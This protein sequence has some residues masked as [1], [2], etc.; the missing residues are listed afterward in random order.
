M[1]S[2]M[3]GLAVSTAI[4]IIYLNYVYMLGFPDGHVTEIE[5]AE[6]TIAYLFIAISVP[7]GLFCFASAILSSIATRR[8]I[9]IVVRSC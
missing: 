1:V 9:A 4:A 6:R 8:R 2:L 3:L 7:V 5:S